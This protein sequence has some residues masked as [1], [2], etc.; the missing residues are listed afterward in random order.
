LKKSE[1]YESRT[2]YKENPMVQSREFIPMRSMRNG[3]VVREKHRQSH[4]AQLITDIAACTAGQISDEERDDLM[5]MR[6]EEKVARDV[7][8]RLYDRW[9]LPPFANIS[10]S[11]QVHMDGMLALLEHYGLPDPAEGMD[12]GQFRNPAMQALYDRLTQ[13]GLK[14]E[15][16]AVQVGLLIE[17]LDIADLR[18]AT[19][20]TDKPE[21]L[22]VY[23][24][25]ERGSRNHLRAFHRWMQRLNLHYVPVHLSRHDFES[26]ATSAHENCH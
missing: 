11:E 4:L 7:Y 12:V 8:L 5:M 9:G 19:S 20:R 26:I 16:D 3:N 14:S 21:I 2:A 23:A 6:E 25:L 22:A 13:Q 1:H 18:A 24:N 15:R 10:G 17:E